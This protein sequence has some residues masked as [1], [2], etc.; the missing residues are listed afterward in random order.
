[1]TTIHGGLTNHNP[2]PTPQEEHHSSPNA[3]QPTSAFESATIWQSFR[4]FSKTVRGTSV[5]AF[6]D[7]SAKLAA[8]ERRQAR[9]WI[10]SAE[11]NSAVFDL[12]AMNISAPA[13][14][15][16]LSFQFPEAIG[17]TPVQQNSMNGTIIA[18]DSA[19]AQT[20]A[21]TIGVK[22]NSFTVY[23]TPTLK[24][25]SIVYRVALD[26][27]PLLRADDLMPMLEQAMEK[28]GVVLHVGLYVDPVTRLFFGK[29]YALLDTSDAS[30][31]GFQSLTHEI[32]LDS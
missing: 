6:E 10:Q 19:E 18:F 13:F 9:I 2:P 15:Q 1:M 4:Q 32:P 27:L 8:R 7:T 28:F 30:E 17:A 11:K 31:T 12:K 16:A 5:T 25:D 14:Y 20:K 3:N 26:K 22:V 23:G 29:G 21:C 24:A